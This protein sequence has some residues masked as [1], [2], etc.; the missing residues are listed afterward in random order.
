MTLVSHPIIILVAYQR[1][2]H[3]NDYNNAMNMLRKLMFFVGMLLI[4]PNYYDRQ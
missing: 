1:V 4:K 3:Y 2:I